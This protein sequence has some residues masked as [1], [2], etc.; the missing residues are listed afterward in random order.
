VI[1]S[2]KGI[3]PVAALATENKTVWEKKMNAK[4]EKKRVLVLIYFSVQVIRPLTAD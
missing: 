4:N 3:I 1:E 2:P